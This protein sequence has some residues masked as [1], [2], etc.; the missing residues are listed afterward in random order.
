MIR[1]LLIG[2]VLLNGPAVHAQLR[3]KAISY[4]VQV[5]MAALD[6][7]FEGGEGKVRYYDFEADAYYSDQM[8]RTIVR[9]VGK[10]GDGGPNI[11]Q[12]LYDLKTLD[13]YDID[14]DQRYVLLKKNQVVAPKPTGNSKDIMGYRCREM[15]F[16]DYRGV[17]ITVWVTSKLPRNIC[18]L[19]NYSLDGT[20]LEITTSNGLHFVATDFAEGELNP[21]FFDVPKG[22]QEEVLTVSDN[23]K[24]SK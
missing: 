14:H 1:L 24:K 11:R 2:V 12:R 23:D 15:A 3:A 18:P 5:D 16:S 8:V 17:R 22:Y 20:A 10:H 6:P 21:G 7:S 19:G 13:Q 9:K 4:K